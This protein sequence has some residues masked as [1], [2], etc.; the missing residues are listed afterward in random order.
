MTTTPE[1]VTSGSEMP[2]EITPQPEIG[3]N[4]AETAPSLENA[5][6]EIDALKET[7]KKTNSEAAAHRHKAKELD[8]LKAQIEAEKL[9][10]TEKLQKQLASLQMEHGER[11]RIAQERFIQYEVKLQAAALGIIDPDAASKLIAL[12]GLEYDEGGI[13]TNVDK[14]L[15]D[16]VKDKP[17]LL[18]PGQKQNSTVPTPGPT[19]PQRSVS[20]SP[21]EMS[22]AK[23]SRMT[24]EQY[25]D[26]MDAQKWVREH[27][28]QFGQKLK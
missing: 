10:E 11:T 18:G 5:L 23:I 17:Y 24:A 20:A 25:N 21:G 2:S 28:V 26:N 14:L 27:P 13:P 8:D 19:N 16:L 12:S 6:K 3:K 22:W 1:T 15:K 9:T 7:L 4:S